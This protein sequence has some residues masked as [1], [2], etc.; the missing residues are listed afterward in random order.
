MWVD[1]AQ[2]ESAHLRLSPYDGRSALCRLVFE[3]FYGREDSGVLTADVNTAAKNFCALR[4]GV[5]GLRLAPSLPLALEINH[6][7]PLELVD[8][9]LDRLHRIP[10]LGEDRGV[11]LRAKRGGE[12][13]RVHRTPQ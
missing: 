10:C 5:A 13:P 1:L 3:S 8:A 9:R 6:A 2:D 12:R 4:G 7:L 11:E